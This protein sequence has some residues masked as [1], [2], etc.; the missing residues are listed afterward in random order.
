MGP[1]QTNTT[2]V[3]DEPHPLIGAWVVAST[4]VPIVPEPMSSFLFL[5]GGA[6]LAL[7]KLSGGIKES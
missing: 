2:G 6:T 7:R 4:P 3:G 5:T 1:L